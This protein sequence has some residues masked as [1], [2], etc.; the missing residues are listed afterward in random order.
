M[1]KLHVI[2]KREDLDAARLREQVAIVLDI[3]DALR[4][5]KEMAA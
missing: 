3:D 5:V 2:P 1:P 4:M